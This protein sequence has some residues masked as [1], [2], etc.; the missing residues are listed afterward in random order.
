[1]IRIILI[2]N[3]LNLY[4]VRGL[5]ITRVKEMIL[6]FNKKRIKKILLLNLR[7]I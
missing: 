3:G 5:K 1:M 2:K 4:Y 7:Q 6:N